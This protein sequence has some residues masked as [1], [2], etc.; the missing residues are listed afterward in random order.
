MDILVNQLEDY[1]AAEEY[2]ANMPNE[3]RQDV[4]R[5]LLKIYIS[6]GKNDVLWSRAFD[7]L[8]S[9]RLQADTAEIIKLLPESWMVNDIKNFLI[10][11]LKYNQK[12]TK[13]VRFIS[14]IAKSNNC[15]LIMEKALRS[16]R[17]FTITDD[18]LCPK[19]NQF[20]IDPECVLCPDGKILHKSCAPRQSIR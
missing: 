1:R 13:E 6:R 20:F 16:M 11:G 14:A 15:R 7:L 17:H 8:N 18:R 2:C 10:E 4:L 3:I 5:S 12:R 9:G 19:C